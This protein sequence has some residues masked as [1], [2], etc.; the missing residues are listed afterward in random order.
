MHNRET[1]GFQYVFGPVAS[2]R[3]GLSLGVD[4]LPPKTCTLDCVYCEAGRTNCKTM[5]RKEWVPVDEVLAELGK[6]LD[7]K[8]AL[9]SVTFSGSGEPTLHTGLGFLIGEIHSR[10]P[11]YP[12]TVLTNGTLFFMEEV[13][14]DASR[15]DRVIASYDAAS[16]EVFH[17]LNR[18]CIGLSPERM[19]EGFAD[20][21]KIFPGEFWIEVFV[22]PGVNDTEEEM[23]AL[24]RDLAKVHPDRV[25]LNTLDRPGTASWVQAADSLLLERFR[26]YL[27]QAEAPSPVQ[28]KSL[29]GEMSDAVLSARILSMVKRRPLT[30]EDVVRTQGVALQQADRVLQILLRERLVYRKAMP[31]GDFFV[32]SS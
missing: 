11:S 27:K 10:W 17:T 20:F 26:H 1:R 28:G 14:L 4:L 8:P 16:Q 5:I 21:R 12:V 23:Q 24:A 22:V 31:R 15:A 7:S 13:R 30:L 9:D 19:L 25:Q 29:D 2:R 6:I 18:P 3:L 32:F